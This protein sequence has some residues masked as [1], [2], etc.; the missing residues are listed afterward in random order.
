MEITQQ[1]FWANLLDILEEIADAEFI[2]LDLEMSGIWLKPV[3]NERM[4]MSNEILYQEAK[5]V[6]QT[7][8]IVQFGMTCLRYNEK[9][10]EYMTQTYNFNLTPM[11]VGTGD[12]DKCLAKTI[13]RSL[14]FSYNALVFLK[15]NG[16]SLS[17]AFLNGVPYLSRPDAVDGREEYLKYLHSPQG[18]Y[19]KELAEFE[20]RTRERI[21]SLSS[22]GRLKPT[23]ETHT[24]R[25]HHPGRDDDE[26]TRNK[27]RFVKW[28]V[29]T[30][31]DDYCAW[32]YNDNFIVVERLDKTRRE[33]QERSGR[34][35]DN[36]VEAISRQSAFRF[37][38][39]ALVGSD[40]ANDI[41]PQLLDDEKTTS[42][43]GDKLGEAWKHLKSLEQKIKENQPVIIGHNHF[44][45]LC[46]IYERF[47]G[48]LPSTKNDFRKE[49]RQ[50]FP[51]LV[52]TKHLAYVQQKHGDHSRES[53]ADLFKVWKDQKHPRFV[54]DTS[55]QPEAHHAGHDSWMTAVVFGKM[56]VSMAKNDPKLMELDDEALERRRPSI[57]QLREEKRKKDA[58]KQARRREQRSLERRKKREAIIRPE[59]TT[60][61]PALGTQPP[62]KHSPK[63]PPE[64][65]TTT[66]TTPTSA[67][68]NGGD[69]PSQ[70]STPSSK[71]DTSTSGPINPSLHAGSTAWSKIAKKGTL[72]EKKPGP[73]PDELAKKAEEEAEE[74]AKKAEQEEEAKFG[75]FRI[76]E[77]DMKLWTKHGNILRMRR[78]RSLHL[79]DPTTPVVDEGGKAVDKD[80]GVDPIKGA[81]AP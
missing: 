76:P 47:I 64:K 26:S 59:D 45:D 35:F 56:A 34:T 61:F 69:K 65:P 2:A 21:K 33:W 42:R 73:T 50:L 5:R 79:T 8:H 13:D 28:L 29:A 39:E 36:N 41:T 18:K 23:R 7:F 77:W 15:E 60:K 37:I 40:F 66:A 43:F 1:N 78:G 19:T 9:S 51:R 48:S 38:I 6:A 54:Q 10:K 74:E 20:A 46:F 67:E 17:E 16:F 80:A 49:L 52:D 3:S 70:D 32:R 58:I 72:H 4:T 27:E 81:D 22:K 25:I 71:S 63:W 11:F 53:L 31:L 30:E 12:E 14:T 44:Y 75:P 57:D 68:S 55:Q 24:L 62:A